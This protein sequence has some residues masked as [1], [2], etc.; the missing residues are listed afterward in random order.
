[1]ILQSGKYMVFHLR[2]A[3]CEPQAASSSFGKD[4]TA[5][6]VLANDHG[7][8]GVEVRSL[9]RASY[10]RIHKKVLFLLLSYGIYTIR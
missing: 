8:G 5:F 6:P 7:A 4:R 2:A 1:M 9:V 3:S 10:F